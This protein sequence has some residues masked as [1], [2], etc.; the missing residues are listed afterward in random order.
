VEYVLTKAGG[1]VQLANDG[2]EAVDL[3]RQGNGYDLVI[4]DLQMPVMDG[5]GATQII[6]DEMKLQIPIIAMTATALVGEQVRCLDAGVDE[7]MTKPFDFKELYKK[8]NRLLDRQGPLPLFQDAGVMADELPAYDLG[9]LRQMDDRHYLCDRLNAFIT[10]SPGRIAEMRRA[11]LDGEHEQVVYRAG[12]MKRNARVLQAG[13]LH[14]LLVQI[15]DQSK[16]GEAVTG[17][18]QM[19]Q[20]VYEGM[21]PLLKEEIE[22]IGFVL[23]P[24]E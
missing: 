4:M 1:V 7:Y 5:Y 3:L 11:A 22:Q 6:R 15:E 2:R 18:V 13:V 20:E 17:L 9:L 10:E 16:E 24:E 12:V 23:S 8:I 19:V 21:E 14:S